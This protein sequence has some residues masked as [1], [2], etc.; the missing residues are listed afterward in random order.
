V[1]HFVRRR[2]IKYGEPGG[3][4]GE[5][6]SR[7]AHFLIE[8]SFPVEETNEVMDRGRLPARNRAGPRP[9]SIPRPFSPQEDKSWLSVN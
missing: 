1:A 8:Y 3:A 2:G 9:V 6:L 7:A 4:A 5:L